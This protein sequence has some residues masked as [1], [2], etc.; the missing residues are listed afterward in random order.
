MNRRRVVRFDV[1]LDPAFDARLSREPG[2]ELSVVPLQSAPEQALEKLA[3]A[4]IYHV[5]AAKD[6]LPRRWWV[7]AEL[8]RG[9]P[10]LLCASSYGAG[11]DTI[12]VP[13]CTS[14]GVAVVNQ[15]G[16]NA[17]S[18]AEQTIAFILALSR[19]IVEGDRRLRRSRGFAREEV[20]GREIRGRSLGL[21]GIGHCGS[22]VARV[23]RVFGM[24]VLAF[25]PYLDK[26]EVRRRG[27]E[28]VSFE[29]L[30]AGADFVSLHCPRNAETAGMMDGRAFARMKRGAYFISTARGGI[31]DEAALA[32]AL[33][34]GHLAGAAL[35]VWAEEPP[36][37]SHPLLARDDVIATFHTAG[38][39]HESRR[40]MASMGAEQIAGLLRGE[41]PRNLVNPEVWPR[42]QRRL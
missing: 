1:W 12:D 36:P 15:A 18:V 31:H 2:I 10:Q 41:R 33:E 16:A 7:N 28:A 8:L 26:D 38:V 5:S 11:Y 20:M 35:D 32:A 6:E 17:H 21:V 19:R 24:R 13:A 34:A 29:E 27:A 4:A 42:I 30:L 37:L 22:A 9:C 23:A 40:E 14:A 39:S 3:S 25:D